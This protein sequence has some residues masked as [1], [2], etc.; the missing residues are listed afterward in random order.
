[1]DDADLAVALSILGINA[2]DVVEARWIDN[3]PGWL[4]VLWRQ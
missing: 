3:G 4:G 1:V 2:T